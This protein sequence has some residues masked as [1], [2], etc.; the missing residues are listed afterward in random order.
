MV[1]FLRQQLRYHQ[2]DGRQRVSGFWIPTGGIGPLKLT[3]NGQCVSSRAV[4]ISKTLSRGF[5]F[6]AG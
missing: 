3:E 5:S 6:F 2:E 4:I 1:K